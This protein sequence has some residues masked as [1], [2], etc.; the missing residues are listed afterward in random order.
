MNHIQKIDL[1]F[2]AFVILLSIFTFNCVDASANNHYLSK[3]EISHLLIKGGYSTESPESP[4]VTK[5]VGNK[6][7]VWTYPG[8]QGADIFK[9][10]TK[11]KYVHIHATF[12]SLG[13]GHFS[14]YPN[15]DCKDFGP[16][17][18]VVKR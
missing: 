17:K 18:T 9:L 14:K 4:K 16:I 1:L 13:G 11:G 7:T 6:T 10:T 2:A 12:G 15:K 8:A 3:K 5:R